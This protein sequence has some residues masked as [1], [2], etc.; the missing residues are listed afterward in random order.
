[1][2]VRFLIGMVQLFT[3][4][5]IRSARSI[6]ATSASWVIPGRHSDGGFR[7]IV[8]STMEIG[9]QSV[10]VLARPAFPQTDSTSG[11]VIRMLS[12]TFSSRRCWVSETLGRV[13]GMYMRLPSRRGGMNSLP[14]PAN[15]MSVNANAA[16]APTM[17]STR[18]RR[19]QRSTG[20]YTRAAQ[21][22]SG[23]AASGRIRPLMRNP[24]STGTT[25]TERSA[26]AAM[27][28]VLVSASGR[29]NRP[30]WS[31]RVKTG[32]NDSVM[33]SSDMNSAGPTSVAAAVTIRQW[34]V[35]SFSRSPL[36]MCLCRFSII[37]MAASIMAPIA[38]AMPP[39]DMI[40]ALIPSQRMSASEARIPSGRVAIATRA[41][42][43]WSRKSTQTRPTMTDSSMSVRK[44]VVMDR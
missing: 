23:L 39:S 24:I 35:P 38:M 30:S 18:A 13:F 11:K 25:V 1:M 21:R 2:S 33:M 28:K 19:D 12:C 15:G 5:V 37:T 40:L 44:S 4:P 16:T 3:A 7:L 42:R 27:A 17:T 8:V 29:N 9:A 41:L 10:A 26:A 20:R 34:S 6:S 14:S 31:S 43:A 36:S 32:R 22:L